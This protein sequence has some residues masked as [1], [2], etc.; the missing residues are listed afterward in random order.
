MPFEYLRSEAKSGRMGAKL[1]AV[2]AE[3]EHSRIYLSPTA[4]MEAIAF[5]AKPVD[6]PADLPKKALG[7]RVQEYGMTQWRDLF[8]SRQL[9]VLTTFS[10]LVQEARLL[11]RKRC[12]VRRH[13]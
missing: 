3:G 2:V 4:E 13:G 10:D 8:T 6:S 1:M 11:S 7:F 9:T 5:S 12:S